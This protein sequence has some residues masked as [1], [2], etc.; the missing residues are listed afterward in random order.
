MIASQC[1]RLA[2]SIG[3]FVLIVLA[4]F[5]ARAESWIVVSEPSEGW[6]VKLPSKPTKTKPNALMD[7]YSLQQQDSAFVL[8]VTDIPED[9][10]R[11]HGK[12]GY[13]AGA[14][15]GF[16]KQGRATKTKPTSRD[17]K[18][19]GL[20]GVEVSDSPQED[21]HRQTRLFVHK[22]RL[23]ML[24]VTTSTK[25]SSDQSRFFRSFAVK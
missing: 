13:L 5:D 3:L 6:T 22:Q 24:M 8:I 4:T 20:A 9:K 17:I 10:Y 19:K 1:F 18:Y 7:V 21:L 2:I 16:M 25:A 12:A 11:L 14:V 15:K 23:Y